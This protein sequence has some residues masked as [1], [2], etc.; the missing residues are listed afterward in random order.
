[1]GKS[2]GDRK[3]AQTMKCMETASLRHHQLTVDLEFNSSDPSVPQG[4]LTAT[5]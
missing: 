2:T 5:V 1:M 3:F 4:L